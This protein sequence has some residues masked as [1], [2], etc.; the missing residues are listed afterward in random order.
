[1]FIDRAKIEVRAGN[2]G[3]GS[4]A[5]L[6]E[7]Y[8]AFGGPSGGNGGRGGSIIFVAQK[9]VTTLINFRFSKV[10]A[11]E[12]GGKGLGKNMYGRSAKDITVPVPIGT[13]VYEEPEHKLIAD[14]AKDNDTVIVAKGGRGGR[15]NACF[16]SSVNRTPKIAENGVPG[17]HKKLILELK[18]LADVGLVG[19]PSVGKS[20]LLSV[21]SNARP[22]IG[23][24]DF[25]T[26][27]PNLGV[28]ELPG[29]EP[30]VVA[31][32]PGLIEGAHLGKGL[33]LNFLR[34]LERCRVIV[35]LVDMGSTRDPYKDFIDI[36]NE[37]K[38]YNVG[39]TK[40]P[41]IV[42]ASKMDEV[43][44][45]VR[46]AEFRK[47][48]GSS[49]E[50]FPISALIH[51]GVTDLFYRVYQLLQLTPSM[52]LYDESE[53]ERFKVYDGHDIDATLFEITKKND[54][55]FVITGERIERA[56][57]LINITTDEGVMRLLA[58][59]RKVNIEERLHALGAKD[60][61][62]VMLCDFTFEYIS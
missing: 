33:G 11:A 30:F 51:S 9:G 1:M 16:K 6:K 27:F 49:V 38:S 32:L 50:V 36:N 24:Y 25:T 45:E 10:I 56:Y 35:H 39:L 20:T 40:R 8:V 53:E 37:I 3:D 47:K 31:D 28:V 58:Y 59:L 7:K 5:F 12:D 55:T 43:N 29:I 26:L 19:F 22:E 60:G 17:Q 52:P 23:D 46:L 61:D 42:A 18:L 14:L 21:I 2:G 15:G 62:T 57:H 41:M 4:I 44:A 48:L 13:V 54:H 34:H